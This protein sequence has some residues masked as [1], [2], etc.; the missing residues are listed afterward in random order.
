MVK[1]CLDEGKAIP[2]RT[3]REFFTNS[4]VG[5]EGVIDDEKSG[6]GVPGVLT[7]RSTVF[8]RVGIRLVG[9][10]ELHDEFRN[11]AKTKN[12]TS[13]FDDCLLVVEV[14]LILSLCSS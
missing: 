3:G 12:K 2:A 8:T 1:F 5:D 11:S 7:R 14:F 6:E 10:E 9:D 4:R 13:I